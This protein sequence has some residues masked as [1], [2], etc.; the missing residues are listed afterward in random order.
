LKRLAILGASG[1]GKVVADVALQAGWDD[2]RFYDDRWPQIEILEEWFVIGSTNDLLGSHEEYAGVIV[3]I[4]DNRTRLSKQRDLS[5]AGAE[6]VS[7][8]HP[9]AI[10]ST[11]TIVGRGSVIVG[12]AVVNAY[13]TAGIACIINSGATVD[14]DCELADGVHISPGAHL[15]GGVRVGEASW[16]GVGAAVRHGVSIGA[17]VMV[18]A[19][20]AV[21]RDVADRVTVMGVP[22]RARS[23]TAKQ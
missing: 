2:V 7:I 10:V 15:G 21:V 4:G 20:A 23:T 11:R 12:G 17:D 9:K 16:I 22:A 8:V 13:A 19:G 18:G 6:M 1:H 3:A 14:H 5:A